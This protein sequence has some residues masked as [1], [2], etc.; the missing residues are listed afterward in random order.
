MENC[1]LLFP[2]SPSGFWNLPNEDSDRRLLASQKPPWTSVLHVQ[3]ASNCQPPAYLSAPCSAVFFDYPHFSF[4]ALFFANPLDWQSCSDV[5]SLWD[6]RTPSQYD[7]DFQHLTSNP[8]FCNQGKWAAADR[9]ALPITSSHPPVL[10]HSPQS[11]LALS[12][13]VTACGTW[14]TRAGG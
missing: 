11:P 9:C 1:M 7:D 13:V 3:D 14:G 5:F 6:L 4:I 8:S 2:P 12:T 10:L